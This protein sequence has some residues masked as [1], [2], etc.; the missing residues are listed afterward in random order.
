MSRAVKIAMQSWKGNLYPGHVT[1]ANH[2]NAGGTHL[3][4][5]ALI[6]PVFDNSGKSI[7]F[8]VAAR[9]HHA[10]IGGVAP[11]SMPSDS[12]KL[13]QEG[14]AFEQWKTIPHGK[15]DDEGIQ[16]HLVDVLGSYPGCSPSRRGGHNH[17]AD[18]K[19]QVAANQKGINLIHGL[20]EEYRRETFLFYMWAVKET[21]AIAVEGLLRK[22]AA[23]QMGQRPPTAVDYM[24]EGSRIQLSVS[25]GAEKRTAV[26]DF[27][28]TGHEPFN[29]LSAPIVITHSA[30]LYSLR[31]LIGSDIWLNEGG[32]A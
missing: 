20:F 3:L 2:P 10:E 32:E 31:C 8:F 15:F 23:K 27:T 16:H 12:V 7:D 21:A 5:I 6:P 26:S 17:I 22:T 9:A 24:D 19:A 1:A 30:I 4:D 14:A 13:Y 29:C 11:G 28:G 25:I 18:L